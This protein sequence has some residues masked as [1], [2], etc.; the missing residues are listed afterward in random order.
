MIQPPTGARQETSR[1]S[2]PTPRMTLESTMKNH[3]TSIPDFLVTQRHTHP[4]PTSRRRPPPPARPT[5]PHPPLVLSLSHTIPVRSITEPHGSHMRTSTTQTLEEVTIQYCTLK[6]RQAS[7]YQ[8]PS[9][10]SLHSSHPQPP[11]SPESTTYRAPI[12]VNALDALVYSTKLVSDRREKKGLILIL[13]PLIS[14]RLV[15][16]HK[17]GNGTHTHPRTSRLRTPWLTCPIRW[18]APGRLGCVV[19]ATTQKPTCHLQY[20]MPFVL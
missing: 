9:S 19:S 16:S 18:K 1:T 6:T 5:A 12:A 17:H 2:K 7:T 11:P 8:P 10:R 3:P 13:T 14:S 20:Y 15:S 4:N